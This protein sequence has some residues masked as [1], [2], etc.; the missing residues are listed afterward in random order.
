ME[1]SLYGAKGSNSSERVE[2]VLNFK[3]I[4]YDRI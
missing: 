4:H 3:G 1:V 2:W